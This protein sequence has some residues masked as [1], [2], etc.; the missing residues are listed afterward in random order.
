MEAFCKN[1]K[2]KSKG[3]DGNRM[4]QKE[5]QKCPG[6]EGRQGDEARAYSQWSG[7][8]KSLIRTASSS[9]GDR[10]EG[11]GARLDRQTV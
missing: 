6:G 2:N 3:P 9:R 1:R 5:D 10:R 8:N 11:S 4:Q 7:I